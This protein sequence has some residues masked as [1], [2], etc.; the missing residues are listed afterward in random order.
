[1]GLLD[2]PTNP[3]T[4]E[5]RHALWQRT[6]VLFDDDFTLG[7][8]GWS[9]LRDPGTNRFPSLHPYSCVGP[10]SMVLD[11]EGGSTSQHCEAIKRLTLREESVRWH[12][13]V[14][15]TADNN[16]HLRYLKW[17][18]DVEDASNRYW[19][20]IRYT[21]FDEATSAMN[22]MWHV[23]TGVPSGGM[24]HTVIS[25]LTTELM[26]NQ[27]NKVNWHDVVIE[28]NLST[29]KYVSIEIDGIE[30][31]LS[32]YSGPGADDKLDSPDT[33]FTKGM[34]PLFTLNGRSDNSDA[35]PKVF[36]DWTRF[37]VIS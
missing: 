23:Q 4:Y 6:K 16:N 26:F 31:D 9:G 12:S 5:R 22:P 1:M 37:E 21:H 17:S 2:I 30:T 8:C 20:E 24:T 27:P 15:W 29:R 33:Y 14:G 35:N 11:L 34:N 3:E 13:R 32:G 36:V 25:G 28:F 10:H 18:I 19:Y 7:L